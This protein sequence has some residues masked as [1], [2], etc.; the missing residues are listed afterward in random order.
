MITLMG[1][2]EKSDYSSQPWSLSTDVTR[3]ERFLGLYQGLVIEARL[4]R[5]DSLDFCPG[6][7]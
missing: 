4:L 5:D 2:T 6:S 3:F 7:D 1:H